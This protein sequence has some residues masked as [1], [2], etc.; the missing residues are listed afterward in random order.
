M[1]PCVHPRLTHRGGQIPCHLGA[2]GATP[3]LLTLVE[4]PADGG[5]WP[6]GSTVIA[7]VE[8]LT[9]SNE[10]VR[11]LKSSVAGVLGHA[12]P[13]RVRSCRSYLT[14]YR[15]RP[16]QPILPTSANVWPADILRRMPP[17]CF[18]LPAQLLFDFVE[19]SEH[20]CD[21]HLMERIT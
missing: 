1:P 13:G 15:L 18:H 10:D 12:L 4:T 20:S 6:S 14:A 5:D 2:D 11:L 8:A 9:P 3:V 16:A 21:H 7:T 19:Q 17:R